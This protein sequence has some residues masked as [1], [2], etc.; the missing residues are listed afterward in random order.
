MTTLILA[1]SSQYRSELLEKLGL[2]FQAVS[3]KVDESPEADETPRELVERLA[4]LKARTVAASY[5]NALIIGSDQVAVCADNVLGKPHTEARA[6]AQLAQ[7]SGQT[8]NFLT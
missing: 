4:L 1:S 8:T 5:P 6:R 3:P 2:V 7:L